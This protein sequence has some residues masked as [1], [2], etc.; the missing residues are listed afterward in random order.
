[1]FRRRGPIAG[2]GSSARPAALAVACLLAGAV[3]SACIFGSEANSDRDLSQ[4]FEQQQQEK[5]ASNGDDAAAAAGAGSASATT[6]SASAAAQQANSGNDAADQ[7]ADDETDG[8]SGIAWAT[9]PAPPPPQHF[10][11][12]LSIPPETPLAAVQRFFHLIE[13]ERYEEAWDGITEES[14]AAVPR[15]AFVQRYHDINREATIRGMS[16]AV[17]WQGDAEARNFDVIIRYQT[18]FYGEVAETVRA[19]VFRQGEYVVHWTPDMIFDGLNCNGCLIRNNIAVPDRG[20]ILDRNG[21]AVAE[22]RGVAIVGLYREAIEPDE[23]EEVIAFFTERLGLQRDDVERRLASGRPYSEFVPVASLPIETPGELID[24]YNTLSHLGILLNFESRRY[25]P[26]GDSASHVIGYLQ[27]INADELAARY[28]DG[29]RSGD[30]IGRVGIERSW[31]DALAGRRGGQLVIVDDQGWPLRVIA[32]RPAVGGSDIRLTLDIR[33]QQLTEEALGERPGAVVA[34]D[35]RS[36]HIIAMASYPRI[37]LNDIV[38]GFTQEEVDR[39]FNDERQPFVNRATQQVYAPGSTFKTITL[40]AALE[41]GGFNIDDRISCPALW[42]LGN[43][44]PLRNWKTVDR[45]EM[46]LSQALAESCNTVFYEIARSLDRRD[47]SLLSRVAGGFGFGL[48]TGV[49]GI[50]EEPG[51]NPS[52]AWKIANRGDNWYTGD[53]INASIGQ[54]YVSVTALQMGNAYGAIATT[55]VLYTPMAVISIEPP[56]LEPTLLERRAIGVLPVSS[57]TLGDLQQSLRDVIGK[58]YGT[59]FLPFAN[60]PLQAAGKSG[61]AEDRVIDVETIA[62]VEADDEADQTDASDELEVEDEP[63]ATP[64]PAPAF[65]THAWFVAWAEYENP[66][67]LATVVLDDGVSGADNAGPIA[68]RV[69][70]GALANDWVD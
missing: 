38:D 51:V 26:F 39:Y 17:D 37:D 69:L 61:T 67:L 24:E 18:G 40:A 21:E 56:G 66:R 58:P 62:S 14:R 22:D 16:W 55:G 7:D 11:E 60:S 64:P 52:P 36:G 29:Y 31:N 68:R 42:R 9:R 27:E 33:V 47:P 50:Y 5:Q 10:L 41:E 25:Y 4:A 45:G 2:L 46:P 65:S 23:R 54:G 8:G 35:P 19:I 63:A 20:S 28:D 32:E 49:V 44:P 48:P 34:L 57:K 53:A 6:G 1:M 59:G 15:D 12:D 13:R 43:Q 30:L 70:E 3:L